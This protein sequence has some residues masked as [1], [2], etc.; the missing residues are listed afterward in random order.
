[1]PTWKSNKEYPNDD[2]HEVFVIAKAY[3]FCGLL[4][5]QDD[6]FND[7]PNFDKL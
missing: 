4:Y 6:N 7:D 3:N 5:Y 2:E 1:M